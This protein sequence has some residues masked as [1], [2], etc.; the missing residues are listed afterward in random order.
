MQSVG[1][2]KRAWLQS[3][4]TVQLKT[5]QG[6]IM[7]RQ[8]LTRSTE[9]G[10][11][12]P[13]FKKLQRL[14]N[15][16]FKL[17]PAQIS[18]LKAPPSFFDQLFMT[19]SQVGSSSDTQE[20]VES[21]R[22]QVSNPSWAAKKGYVNEPSPYERSQVESSLSYKWNIAV[23]VWRRIR[24]GKMRKQLV[25]RRAPLDLRTWTHNSQLTKQKLKSLV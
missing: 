23:V 1:G 22:D 24:I 15:S 9:T 13:G 3:S 12:A 5:S 2:G 18:S 10:H 25:Q 14:F 8:F 11:V 7:E 17:K 19:E 21:D 6:H 4:H 16:C 20:R